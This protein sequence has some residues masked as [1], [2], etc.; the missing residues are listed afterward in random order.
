MI[1]I[2]RFLTLLPYAFSMSISLSI[3]IYCLRRRN[4][5]GATPY[6]WLALTQ[7][8][9]VAAFMMRQVSPTLDEKIFW[10]SLQ[11]FATFFIPYTYPIF[12]A[13]FMGYHTK[14]VKALRYIFGI[15]PI[16]MT[17]L[18]LTNGYH[19]LIYPNPHL[20]AGDPFSTLEYNFTWLIQGYTLY[21]VLVVLLTIVVLAERFVHPHH[22]YRSQVFAIIIASLIPSIAA[23][24]SLAGIIHNDITPITFTLRNLIVVWALFRYRLFDIIPVAHERLFENMADPVIVINTSNQVVDINQTALT[25]IGKKSLDIIGQPME[26]VFA[27]WKNFLKSVRDTDANSAE[28]SLP[29]KGESLYYKLSISNISDQRN[30]AIGKVFIL[31]DITRRKTLEDGYRR[32]SEELEGRVEERTNELAQAYDTTL[33]GWA[34]ALELRDK[35]TEGHSRRVTEMTMILA[36]A[37]NIPEDEL[38]HIRRGA[39]LHDIGKMAVPDEILRKGGDLT[40]S[41]KEIVSHHPGIAY[42]LLLPIQYLEKALEIP[43]CHHER[44]DG[45]GYPRGLKGKQIPLSARIFTVADIWNAL[46]SDRPYRKAWSKEKTLEYMNAQAG[47]IFDP[48]VLRVFLD[49]ERKGEI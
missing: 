46:L 1:N 2:P 40:E 7:G 28:F 45:S 26:I 29:I 20:L 8:F 9:L 30:Q 48:N 39:L 17:I 12:T 15:V 43:Y 18:L 49:M 6:G 5:P 47:I 37:L 22:L 11:W 13:Q 27:E 32:L 10:T 44:W 24:F 16:G 4:V 41:E 19:H 34:K 35:E 42:E 38:I 33:E 23:I 21:S 36:R 14:D 31:Y 3:G 25:M